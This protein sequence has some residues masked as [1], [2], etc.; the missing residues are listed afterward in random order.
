MLWRNELLSLTFLA[1]VLFDT[2]S[3]LTA[4]SATA[5]YPFGEEEDNHEVTKKEAIVALKTF[6]MV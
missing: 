2:S 6:F 3:L 5:A 4:A 1:V